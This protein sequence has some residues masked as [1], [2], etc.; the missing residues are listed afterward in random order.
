MACLQLHE[1]KLGEKLRGFEF[2][3]QALPEMPELT[4]EVSDEGPETWAPARR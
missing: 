2:V 3:L 1:R 4:P